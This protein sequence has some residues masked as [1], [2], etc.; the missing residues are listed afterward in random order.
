[1]WTDAWLPSKSVWRVSTPN[2]ES[3]ADLCVVELIDNV[4]GCWNTVAL[5]Q[6]LSRNNALEVQGLPLSNRVV[7]DA[8]F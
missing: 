8:L 4:N 5:Y 7:K 1:M 6:H 3:L 2:L